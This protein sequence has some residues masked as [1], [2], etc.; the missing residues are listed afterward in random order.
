M[1]N[2]RDVV[3]GMEQPTIRMANR[4]MPISAGTR[5][6]SRNRM[7]ANKAVQLLPVAESRSVRHSPEPVQHRRHGNEYSRQYEY[8]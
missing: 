6:S 5:G 7:M 4:M 1:K 8:I 2:D 3:A